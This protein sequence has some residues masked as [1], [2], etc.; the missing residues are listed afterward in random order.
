ML[1]IPI[2]NCVFVVGE[3]SGKLTLYSGW[4]SASSD[5]K[6]CVCVCVLAKSQAI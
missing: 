2:Y 5:I 1:R 4:F 6:L 3:M